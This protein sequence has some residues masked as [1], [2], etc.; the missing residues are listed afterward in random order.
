[1]VMPC[2]AAR[3]ERGCTNAAYP[4]GRAMA[5]PVGTSA[6]CPGARNTSC[7]ACRSAPASPGWAYLGTGRSRSRREIS[8]WTREGFFTVGVPLPE[9]GCPR[10][11]L[12]SGSTFATDRLAVYF[13]GQLAAV[14]DQEAP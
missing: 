3:P 7:R 1:M 8:T 4:A 11:A 12:G 14:M 9:T 10:C 13:L 5:T 6:R 2:L